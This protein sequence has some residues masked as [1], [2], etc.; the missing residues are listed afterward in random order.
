MMTHQAPLGRHHQV[1][2]K[3]LLLH[4]SGSGSPT[5]VFLPGAGAVGLDYLNV[6]ERAA[7]LTT[8][9]LYDRAGTGWSEHAELP[10]TAAEATSELRELL[11]AADVPV[12][13]LL[14]GHSLGGLYARLYATRYPAEVAGLA[15]LDPAHEDLNAYMPPELVQRWQE[16]DPA[17]AQTLFDELPEEVTEFYRGL[18]AQEM[19]DW[20]AEIREPLIERHV[21][22]QWLRRGIAEAANLSWIYDEMRQARPLPDVPMIVLCS[23]AV[24]A[25]KRAVSAGQSEELLDAEI[26]GKW[27]LCTALAASVP[28]GEVRAVDAGHV[29]MHLRHPGLV[30]QAIQ[31]LLTGSTGRSESRSLGG[32]LRR[33]W[34][35]QVRSAARCVLTSRFL[36][37]PVCD[38][39]E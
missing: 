5:V 10:R 35:E 17:Q 23:M 36:G 13:Y 14:V 19:T 18:F 12:P 22:P 7:E 39:S 34:G 24:D 21:S 29:T 16:W 38:F 27:R 30:V 1:A 33:G 15:L 4:R 31:D 37:L 32:D 3:R 8:S 28:R 26:D 11:R 9:V 2:G 25:F 6:Q 20:P